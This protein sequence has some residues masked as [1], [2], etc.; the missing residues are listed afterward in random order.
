MH[1][2]SQRL[3]LANPSNN[4]PHFAITLERGVTNPTAILGLAAF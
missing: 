3:G 1:Y 4:F 2:T